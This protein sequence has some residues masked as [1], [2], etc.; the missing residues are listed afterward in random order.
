MIAALARRW[1]AIRLPR[2]SAEA[3]D[4]AFAAGRWDFLAGRAEGARLAL[5]AHYVAQAKPAN[6]TILDLGCGE[7]LL[8]PGIA[9]LPY[10]RYT[11]VALSAVA[12]ERARADAAPRDRFEVGDAAGYVPATAPDVIVLN[13]MLYY[14]PDPDAS[15]RALLAALAPGGSLIVSIYDKRK[16]RGLWRTLAWRTRTVDRARLTNAAGT[17]WQVA[18]LKPRDAEAA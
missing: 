6:G 13:E 3:W 12:I 17:K 1:R 8:R 4:D 14:L 5:V 9:H 18:W 11:G 10:A 16:T 7:G 2:P 15:V